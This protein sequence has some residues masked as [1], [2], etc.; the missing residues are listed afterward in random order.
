MSKQRRQELEKNIVADSVE[1]MI[2]KIRPYLAYIGIAVGGALLIFLVWATVDHFRTKKLG[3]IWGQYI[4]AQQANNP[5]R[6][7]AD[8]AKNNPE[9]AA[10]VWALLAKGDADLQTG[11]RDIFESRDDASGTLKSAIESF[12]AV[13][14]RA[15]EFPDLARHAQYGIGVAHETRGDIKAAIEAYEKV[16][17]KGEKSPMGKM[18]QRRLDSLRESEAQEFYAWFKSQPSFERNTNSGGFNFP[19]KEH[20]NQPLPSR[21]PTLPSQLDNLPEFPNTQIPAPMLPGVSV[22]G[23]SDED[24]EGTDGDTEGTDVDPEGDKPEGDKPEGDKPEGDKPEGDKPEGDKPEGDKPEGDKPEGDKPEG[25]NTPE[26]GTDKPAT[27]EPTE[28][29]KANGDT[30]AAVGDQTPNPAP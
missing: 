8:L 3:K 15:T 28:G 24:R 11:T 23:D 9:T 7:L 30:P 20:L 22:G 12:E 26:T 6:A 1:S 16:V 10:A 5:D 25:D 13:I 2:T 4:S 27:P 21:D 14:D 19:G 17:K 29:A 18:A